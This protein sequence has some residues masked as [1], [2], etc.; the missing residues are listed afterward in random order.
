MGGSAVG[1]S[2]HDC[3]LPGRG[4]WGRCAAKVAVSCGAANGPG[5]GAMRCMYH[6]PFRVSREICAHGEHEE[7][8]MKGVLSSAEL[9]AT[10]GCQVE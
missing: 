4:N 1:A 7:G 10:A 9:F 2:A 8:N 5:S 6:Q 3:V